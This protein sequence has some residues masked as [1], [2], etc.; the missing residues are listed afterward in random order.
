[1][2]Y[3]MD[4]NSI[5]VFS[6]L[7]SCYL[8]T[9]VTLGFGDIN[10]GIF[11]TDL[12][13][14][15]IFLA[16]LVQLYFGKIRVTKLLFWVYV[17]VLVHA[18]IFNYGAHLNTISYIKSIVGLI[19]MSTGIFSYFFFYRERYIKILNS[20][21][22]LAYYI[23]LLSIIQISLFVTTG[24]TFKPQGMFHGF[25]PFEV[26]MLGFLPRAIGLSREPAHFAML[27]LPAII[28]SVV[29][30]LRVGETFIKLKSHHQFVIILSFIMSFSVVGYFCFFICL[31]F[32]YFNYMKKSVLLSMIIAFFMMGIIAFILTSSLRAKFVR[33]PDMV[34][35]Y[36]TYRFSVNDLS[37]YA[38]LT[39]ALIAKEALIES[40]FFGTGYNT[41][42][43]SYE[44][45]IYTIF[46]ES[47]IIMYGLNQKGA[48]SLFLLIISEFGIPGVLFIILFVKYFWIKNNYDSEILK[49][50]NNLSF[51]MLFSFGLRNGAILNF[52]LYF[53]LALSYYTYRMSTDE[54]ILKK[55]NEY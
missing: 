2:I 31:L 46:K 25:H 15:F 20:Y 37:G 10:L 28:I 53:F 42:Q 1:M 18:Y 47:Q 35:N 4:R 39:N 48:G 40:N 12:S 38:L 27:L 50:T 13:T 30:Y 52:W 32:I 14:F 34:L 55:K 54:V 24:Y 11:R 29:G 6:I 21:Y 3:R 45:F 16:F 43:I 9:I 49:F 7:T 5:S 22:K 41:H 19:I 23:S 44:K 8:A 36:Q 17:Y 26:E 51:L 33:L